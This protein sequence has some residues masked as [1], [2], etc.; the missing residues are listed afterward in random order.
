MTATSSTAVFAQVD[1]PVTDFEDVYYYEIDTV[2][3][4]YNLDSEYQSNI[5]GSL[6]I[7]KFKNGRDLG[8]INS[9]DQTDA[10]PW[11]S[12]D[13]L[14]LYF[15][16][17]FA[18]KDQIVFANRKDIDSPFE[19]LTALNI[20]ASSITS[21]WFSADEL[22]IFYIAGE[23]EGGNNKYI[24][25]ALR[26]S[27]NE[28]FAE[29]EKIELK[30]EDDFGFISGA[31]LTQDGKQLFLYQSKDGTRI[32]R[33]TL[34]G[35]NEYSLVGNLSDD[36]ARE[37]VSPGQL[38]KDGLSYYCPRNGGISVYSRKNITEEFALS[39]TIAIGSNLS[40]LG[41]N[42]QYIVFCHSPDNTWQANDLYMLDNPL[43]K[44]AS[45][46]EAAIAVLGVESAVPLPTLDIVI[47]PNPAS[48][49]VNL[50]FE[51]PIVLEDAILEL[52]DNQGR[53]LRNVQV[54]GAGEQTIQMNVSDLPAGTYFC[55]LSA[56]NFD[57]EVKTLVVR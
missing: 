4:D 48:E 53:V 42:E 50:R 22:T 11:L 30:G 51:L 12:A 49:L 39:N 8:E 28:P 32:L 20:L 52:F 46:D 5:L 40:Q 14:R 13:G 31:S 24:F 33:F 57:A 29:G 21:G 19:G 55:R 25:K 45:A 38:S 23:P 7:S 26:S 36:L 35:E 43:Y 9:A 56:K 47:F 18:E 6:D 15:T 41:F 54:N 2:V 1:I 3:D 27:R 17:N 37:P 16:Q 34:S 10:Y 44:G